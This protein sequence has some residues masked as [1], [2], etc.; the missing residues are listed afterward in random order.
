M[1]TSDPKKIV[2]NFL[3]VGGPKC[4]TTSLS[5]YLKQHPNIF[6]SHPK[7][8]HFWASDLPRTKRIRE[9][10]DYEQ[11]FSDVGPEDIA[12][13]EGS[14][15]SLYSKVALPKIR[16]FNPD[17]KLIVMVRNPVEVVQS[18][19]SFWYSISMEDQSD[20]KKAWELQER[21][22][23]GEALPKMS[24]VRALYQYSEIAKFGKQLER[25]LKV[26]PEN[27]IKIVFFEDLT[28]DTER[29]Y[30]EVL[31]F[32]QV[33]RASSPIDFGV[34]NENQVYRSRILAKFVRR[35]PTL[36]E[37][38]I[39]GFK[40]VTGIKNLYIGHFLKEWEKSVNTKPGRR[41]KIDEA[42]KQKLI[43]EFE[44]DILQLQKLTGRDLSHWLS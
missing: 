8:P 23:K 32:L 1:N 3:I 18:L 43:N 6:F 38:L 19:H 16:E 36:L 21:R 13:G 29:V 4:G 17:A 20:F 40:R 28:S 27:Q 34:H 39:V 42:M 15:W 5:E 35:V 10:S 31:D 26:F 22:D 37:P 33:P 41:K 9:F 2:P 14:V 7:E 11:L 44:E 30:N 12:A 24:K 25:A